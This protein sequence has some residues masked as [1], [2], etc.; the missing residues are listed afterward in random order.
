MSSNRSPQECVEQML[1]GVTAQNWDALPA[2][3]R[4]DAVVD[5]PFQLPTPTRLHGRGALAEHF[6]LAGRLP[7]R[8]SARNLVVHATDDP[9][10]VIAEFDYDGENTQTG[11]RFSFPNIF[12]VHTREGLIAESRDYSDHAVLAAAFDRLD[13]V[14]DGLKARLSS[15]GPGT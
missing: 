6:A 3:Y 14:C 5:H 13:D 4:E 7:L 10:T 9:Q 12:V 1:E 15:A 11:V 2:L 8:L